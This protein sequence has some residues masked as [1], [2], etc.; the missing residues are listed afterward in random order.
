MPLP[1]LPWLQALVLQSV[2]PTLSE[3]GVVLPLSSPCSPGS[4]AGGE[5]IAVGKASVEST[6]P[7]GA[8]FP[9]QRE[10]IDSFIV[11]LMGDRGSFIE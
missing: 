9:R 3:S 7:P 6:V 5:V 2:L 1:P 8:V 10:F 4:Q 11:S